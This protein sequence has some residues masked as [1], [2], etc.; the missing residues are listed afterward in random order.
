MRKRIDFDIHTN[1]EF[2]IGFDQRKSHLGEDAEESFR[3]ILNTLPKRLTK[4]W[5]MIEFEQDDKRHSVGKSS[6][7]ETR[8]DFWN[9]VEISEI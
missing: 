7:K 4:Q 5:W 2:G 9:S 8:F 3:N 6:W 1:N